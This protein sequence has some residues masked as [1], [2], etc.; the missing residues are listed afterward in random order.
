MFI[1]FWNSAW[2]RRVM[3]LRG[4][5]LED[6]QVTNAEPL[7]RTHECDSIIREE[8]QR[9]L[10]SLVPW[11]QGKKIA[12]SL[13]VAI[14]GPQQ[15]PKLA[16]WLW[17]SWILG[18]LSCTIYITVL[19]RQ[20]LSVGFLKW[21]C[22]CTMR[23]LW[24]VCNDMWMSALWEQSPLWIANKDQCPH[25]PVEVERPLSPLSSFWISLF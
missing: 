24:A 25:G 23:H 20:T 14:C 16:S 17:T 12:V 3:W 18:F 11:G 6:C 4:V 5:A 19:Q 13:E 15:T 1:S 10:L 21:K 7:W 2:G 8:T 22:T 9:A